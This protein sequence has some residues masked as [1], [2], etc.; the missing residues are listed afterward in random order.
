MTNSGFGLGSATV[1]SLRQQVV[2]QRAR[3]ICP[4]ALHKL[5]HDIGRGVCAMA[6]LCRSQSYCSADVSTN[7]GRPCWGISNG[8]RRASYWNGLCGLFP[9]G[10]ETNDEKPPWDSPL[11]NTQRRQR[12]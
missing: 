3:R 12:I 2:V 11:V 7:S 8:S 1:S 4:G 5:Y 6:G 10:E 9:R